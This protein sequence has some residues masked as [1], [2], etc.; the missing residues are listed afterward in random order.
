MAASHYLTTPSNPVYSPVVSTTERNNTMLTPRQST[1]A[2]TA[3]PNSW[4]SLFSD[5]HANVDSE[6]ALPLLNAS[7]KQGGDSL[8]STF[9]ALAGYA[10]ATLILAYH[11]SEHYKNDARSIFIASKRTA[12]E[13]KLSSKATPHQSSS[14]PNG[15]PET[16]P[17][18]SAETP[19]TTPYPLAIP[20]A[21][22]SNTSPL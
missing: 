12:A 4:P 11:L 5:D 1:I 21:A 9:I 2:T 20:R 22:P 10:G 7:I 13:P 18:S 17:A 3:G 19:S 8:E 14:K 6:A 16:R 15:K